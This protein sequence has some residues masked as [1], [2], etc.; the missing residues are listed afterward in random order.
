MNTYTVTKCGA[1]WWLARGGVRK[2]GPYPTRGAAER[3]CT[4]MN[5]PKIEDPRTT[6]E[7][8]IL[9]RLAPR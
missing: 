8:A 4:M 2:M 1:S 5:A 9:R 7:R 3:T 6:A